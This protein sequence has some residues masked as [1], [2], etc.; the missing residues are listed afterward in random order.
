MK[1][2]TWRRITRAELE[3]LK[4]KPWRRAAIVRTY[5]VNNGRVS[6]LAPDYFNHEVNKS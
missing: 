4:L 6:K 3:A 5:P 1:N 2:K